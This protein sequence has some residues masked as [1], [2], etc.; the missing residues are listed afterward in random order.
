[1]TEP[2]SIAMLISGALFAAG[3][4]PIVW[5]RA[6]AWRLADGATFRAEFAHML[7]RSDRLQPALLLACLVSA[8]GFAVSATGTARTVPPPHS[9][10]STTRPTADAV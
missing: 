4:V 6:P 1:M 7:R 10:T 3:T 9:I 2:W 8:T 5:E